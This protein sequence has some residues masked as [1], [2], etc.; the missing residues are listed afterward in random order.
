[1]G[2]PLRMDGG[3]RQPS[4][5]YSHCAAWHVDTLPHIHT[6]RPAP[7]QAYHTVNVHASQPSGPRTHDQ[8]LRVTCIRTAFT[9]DDCLK[10]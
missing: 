6:T 2:A 10:V 7:R 3:N 9:T 8:N 5:T 1:M 4:S